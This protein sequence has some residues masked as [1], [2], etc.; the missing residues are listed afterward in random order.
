MADVNPIPEGLRTLTP[1]LTLDGAT[2]AIELYKK[3]FGAEVLDTAMDP[4]GKKVWHSS[5]RFGD[6]VLFINDPFPEMGG[7]PAQ[8]ADLWLYGKDVDAAFKRAV[9][10]GLKVEQ[11][12]T[13]QFWG[14]RTGTLSDRF[15]VRWTVG[16]R[17]KNVSPDELK[18]IVDDMTAK[19][20]AGG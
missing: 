15:G 3:A 8:S 2:A 6:S 20:K 16:Q 10:A 18:K 13:D 9:D 1:Q 5:V 19:M 17:M 14:D 7:H 4:S 11:P 12:L